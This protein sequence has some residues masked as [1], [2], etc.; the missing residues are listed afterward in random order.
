MQPVF[1]APDDT[2]W[3]GVEAWEKANPSLDVTVFF[4]AIFQAS[5]RPVKAQFLKML[6]FGL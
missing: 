4:A 5:I 1:S 6:A 2:N 3:Y